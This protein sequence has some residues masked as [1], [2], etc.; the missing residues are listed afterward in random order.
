MRIYVGETPRWTCTLE[1][2]NWLITT[3]EMSAI[4]DLWWGLAKQD[5]GI[6]QVSMLSMNRFKWGWSSVFFKSNFEKFWAWKSVSHPIV[7]M[8]HVTSLGMQQSKRAGPRK[9]IAEIPQS[10]MLAW[11]LQC[12]GHSLLSSGVLILQDCSLL[13]SELLANHIEHFLSSLEYVD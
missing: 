10:H 11:P 2:T 8:L 1:T 3:K 6:K 9:K 5:Q 12:F 4:G 13:R 7:V